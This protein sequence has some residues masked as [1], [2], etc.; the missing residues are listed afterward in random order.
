MS[1][2]AD[3]VD[4]EEELDGFYA[5]ATSLDD[6]AADVLRI[7]SF[8]HEIEHIFRTTKTFLEARPVFLSR[9]DR[10]KTH[11]LV[12]F[13]VMVILKMLQRQLTEAYPES[14]AKK[15]LSIDRL[16]DTLRNMRF[17]Q[18]EG[19]GYLPMFTRTALTDQLQ[20]LAGVSINTQI[21]PTRQMTANYRNVKN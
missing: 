6:E 15:P 21:I 4:P 13:L 8:H 14:Y 12:C 2:N 3:V 19:Y 16:I 7:R 20:K 10:I 17:A 1:I 9:Q 11:F 18:V 5:Y